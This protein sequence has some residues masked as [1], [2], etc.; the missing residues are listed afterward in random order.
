MTKHE[1]DPFET[2]RD[3]DGVG[4][5]ETRLETEPEGDAH[6]RHREA[7]R[8]PSEDLPREGGATVDGARPI[9]VLHVPL[10]TRFNYWL[11]AVLLAT[12]LALLFTATVSHLVFPVEAG[13]GQWS[14]WGADVHQWR[15]MTYGILCGLGVLILVHLML[16]WDWIC[17]VTV[18]TLLG[19]RL[20]PDDGRRTLYGVIVLVAGLVG[21][22]ALLLAAE[23][24]LKP[25]P[26]E[27][28]VIV[29]KR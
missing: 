28:R 16:H 13:L 21:L 22:G 3:V 18:Q 24:S 10:R 6:G 19:T 29:P 8:L 11:D 20:P 23:L 25:P 5:D 27:S 7:R 26:G 15:G 12:F 14:V 9:K 4:S 2:S 17:Q 1:R